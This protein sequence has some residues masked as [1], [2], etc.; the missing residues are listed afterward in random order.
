MAGKGEKVKCQRDCGKGC[1][2]GFP[3]L[4]GIYEFPLTG[5]G[6][7]GSGSLKEFSQG[8]VKAELGDQGGVNPLDQV[9]L[10]GLDFGLGGVAEFL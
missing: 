6:R 10:G 5:E 9:V 3:L 2:P 7:P 8:N 1:W 4:G